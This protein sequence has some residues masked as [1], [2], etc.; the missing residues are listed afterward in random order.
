MRCHIILRGDSSPLDRALAVVGHLSAEQLSGA[1][2]DSAEG[3]VKLGEVRRDADVASGAVVLTVALEP[4]DGLARLV[5]AVRAGDREGLPV[6]IEGIP[7]HL[8]SPVGLHVQES[9]ESPG[10]RKGP[11]DECGS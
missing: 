9:R 3:C 5:A 11:G 6:G 4:S 1:I 10:A 2:G 8:N 7:G